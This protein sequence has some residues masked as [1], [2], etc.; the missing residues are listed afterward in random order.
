MKS[1]L[2]KRCVSFLEHS[3]SQFNYKN[4]PTAQQPN[5]SY[6]GQDKFYRMPQSIIVSSVI[7]HSLVMNEL[8]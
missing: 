5:Y 4:G 3:A 6:V 1:P 2:V 8:N 7:M